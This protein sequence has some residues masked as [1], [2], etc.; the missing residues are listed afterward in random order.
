MGQVIDFNPDE[1]DFQEGTELVPIISEI[2]LPTDFFKGEPEPQAL[3]DESSDEPNII[4]YI[5]GEKVQINHNVSGNL[6]EKPEELAFRR[7]IEDLFEL[8]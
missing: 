4:A 1:W 5:G 7:Q 8:L 3:F 2:S 6:A